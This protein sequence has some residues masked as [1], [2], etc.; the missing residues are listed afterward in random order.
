MS[1]SE[2]CEFK[3][4]RKDLYSRKFWGNLPDMLS[5]LGYGINQN[6]PNYKIRGESR[7]RKRGLSP[8]SDSFEKFSLFLI[9]LNF[10]FK[11]LPFLLIDYLHFYFS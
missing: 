10:S 4:A 2:N 1:F 3:K 11:I 8:E 6:V 9:F 7:E 5:R